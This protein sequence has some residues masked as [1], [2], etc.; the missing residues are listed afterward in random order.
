MVFFSKNKKSISFLFD[1]LSAR[2]LTSPTE[3]SSVC[4]THWFCHSKRRRLR[5]RAKFKIFR[6]I[7]TAK[8][9]KQKVWGVFLYLL[10]GPNS[11]RLLPK[12]YNQFYIIYPN[13]TNLVLK[14]TTT[15]SQAREPTTILHF[16]QDKQTIHDKHCLFPGDFQ[17]KAPQYVCETLY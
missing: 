16:K 9:C 10:Q 12:K 2:N 13:L 17:Q 15:R 7:W 3:E 11:D 8:L 6:I 1:K 14:N 5:S 4:C